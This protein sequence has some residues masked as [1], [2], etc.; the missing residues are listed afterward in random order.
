[1][2]IP[3]MTKPSA[4]YERRKRMELAEKTAQVIG[5]AFFGLL[6]SG[7]VSFGMFFA[8]IVSERETL[9]LPVSICFGSMLVSG[10]L[11]AVYGTRFVDWIAENWHEFHHFDID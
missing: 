3:P 10:I 2:P 8:V 7:C 4:A 9:W 11:G 1:M 6:A 5:G